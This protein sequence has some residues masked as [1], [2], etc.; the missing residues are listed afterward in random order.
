LHIISLIAAHV[1]PCCLKSFLIGTGNERG[2]RS[3][4]GGGSRSG[5]QTITKGRQSSRKNFSP[6]E[7]KLKK[8]IL[9]IRRELSR[10]AA[11]EELCE[12]EECRDLTGQFARESAMKTRDAIGEVHDRYDTIVIE[13]LAARYTR[14]DGN[15]YSLSTVLRSKY[16][17][18][19]VLQAFLPKFG[20]WIGKYVS[21]CILEH[22]L[23]TP[24]YRQIVPT[25][26]RRLCGHSVNTELL[27]ALA[28]EYVRDRVGLMRFLAA[29][30]KRWR[31][32]HQPCSTWRVKLVTDQ[33]ANHVPHYRIAHRLR[34]ISAVPKGTAEP[35]TTAYAKLRA[36]IKKVRSLAR[37]AAAKKSGDKNS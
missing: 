9:H 31:K 8:D 2:N 6:K 32:I 21:E 10:E 26:T 13:L 19:A 33:H 17:S 7:A 36:R 5:E 35:G 4:R 15:P 14:T 20:N 37:K 1:Q 23:F 3:T 18:D 28:E 16:E 24:L 11:Y 30:F 27:T 34:K 22:S 12:E 25:H 29:A